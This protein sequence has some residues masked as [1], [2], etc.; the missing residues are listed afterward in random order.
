MNSHINDS[1]NNQKHVTNVFLVFLLLLVSGCTGIPVV[2]EKGKS[3]VAITIDVDVHA[4]ITVLQSFKPEKVFYIKLDNKDDTLKKNQIIAYGYRNC[5]F[6][7]ELFGTCN[8]TFLL[9]ADPGIYAAV[10][11]YG[12]SGT[13]MTTIFFPED[14]IKSTI[15]TVGQDSLVYMG[16]YEF[17]TATLFRQ[18]ETPDDYQKHYYKLALSNTGDLRNLIIPASPLYLAVK[19]K[20]IFNSTTDE[21]QFLNKYIKEFKD[22]GLENEIVN[23]LNEL[24]K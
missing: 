21:K 13:V 7:N 5:P 16:R 20:K 14:V 18:M 6:F 19:T 11:A 17:Y 15:V 4:Q 23:R 24:K 22:S 10:G 12:K 2:A 1:N 9:N 8:D 3:S